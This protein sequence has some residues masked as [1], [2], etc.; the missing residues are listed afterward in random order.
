MK[1][2]IMKIIFSGIIGVMVF[3]NANA[4]P[5]VK[6]LGTQVP[7][8][9]VAPV[10][11]NTVTSNRAASVRFDTA[12]TTTAAPK[13]ASPTEVDSSRMLPSSKY[14]QVAHSV[15]PGTSTGSG[16]TPAPSSEEIIVIKDRITAVE[17]DMN[18]HINN[19][20]VHVT[21]SE[22][23]VWNEKQ[24]RL[25]AGEGIEI[26]DNVISAT[27][28]LPVGSEDAPHTAPIWVE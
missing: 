6:K 17:N 22:K 28:R 14:L 1:K 20:E 26:E 15:K 9:S 13:K 16:T 3:A 10:K 8:N 21:A 4:A 23:E 25:T 19:T 24:D 12:K 18:D 11:T 5:T 2:Q 7:T 27:M